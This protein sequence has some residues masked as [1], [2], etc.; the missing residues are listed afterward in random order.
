MPMLLSFF[1]QFRRP[2]NAIS[3]QKATLYL[4]AWFAVAYNI[5]FVAEIWGSFGQMSVTFFAL[6]VVMLF[7]LLMIN[8]LLLNIL[9]I[10]GIFKPSVVLL[11]LISTILLYSNLS[12]KQYNPFAFDF[13]EWLAGT[14]RF[15]TVSFFIALFFL[16]VVP[17]IILLR[18]EIDW[19]VTQQR[20]VRTIASIA[21]TALILVS[22]YKVTE[23]R[24][25]PIYQVTRASLHNAIPMHFIDSS[26][27]FI[28]HEYFSPIH[29][30]SILD[31]APVI[32]PKALHKT[33][34]LVVSESIR[35]DIFSQHL[36]SMRFMKQAQNSAITS[37]NTHGGD[38]IECIFS[39]LSADVFSES[40]AA[41]QQ[42]VLDLL[43]LSGVNIYWLTNQK[44]CGSL[45]ARAAV[46]E[47]HLACNAKNCEDL[48]LADS[49]LAETLNS[50]DPQQSNLIVIQTKNIASPLYSRFYPKKYAHQLPECDTILVASCTD[51]Q[52]RNSYNNA[53]EYISVMLNHVAERLEMFKQ[54]HNNIETALVFTSKYGESLGEHSYY[55][56]GSPRSTA[57]IEQ[58]LVPLLILDTNLP[59]NCL[60]RMDEKLSHDIISHTLLGQFHVQTKAY[61]LTQDLQAVCEASNIKSLTSTGNLLSANSAL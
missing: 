24:L 22:V 55:F 25:Q 52:L 39:F 37:C 51:K 47:V 28:S 53:M 23:E 40:K 45:C 56:H 15:F 11:F 5:P 9:S 50:I 29:S 59:E 12:G 1:S 44:G 8:F 13:H 58:L 26:V 49:L 33:V 17:S 19:G 2:N 42:N 35:A 6:F 57:P 34:V 61:Q 36:S 43:S 27:K 18:T 4:S 14:G 3:I 21:F 38:S 46:K 41:H 16:F 10:K 54:Q 31:S 32:S 48:E 60:A 20:L 30:F 7:C